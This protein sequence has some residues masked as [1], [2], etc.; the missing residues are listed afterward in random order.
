MKPERLFIHQERFLI[1]CITG[2]KIAAS[3]GLILIL[4]W[5]VAGRSGV[6]AAQAGPPLQAASTPTL[7]VT[8]TLT[9]TL[10]TRPPTIT[11]TPT[12]LPLPA[13][14]FQPAERTP[15]PALLAL[16]HPGSRPA[17]PK[18]RRAPALIFLRR[19]GLLLALGGVWLVLGLWLGIVLALIRRRAK[20][21]RP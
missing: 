4:F 12:F 19:W 11:P 18:E 1:V 14:T 6:R 15:T 13:I 17:P 9:A 2:C 21:D 20:D 5:A 16:E 3:S 10:P 7:P 8:G